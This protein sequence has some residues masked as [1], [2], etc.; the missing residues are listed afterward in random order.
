MGKIVGR[1][2]D[3]SIISGVDVFPS[4][5]EPYYHIVLGRAGSLDTLAIRVEITKAAFYGWIDDLRALKKLITERP[6]PA[7]LVR[8]RVKLVEPGTLERTDG[9]ATRV[10]AR[11]P[12]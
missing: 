1:T 12:A 5:V 9:Q 4:A 11:R 2:D 10:V 7:L 3:T 8:P 6:R